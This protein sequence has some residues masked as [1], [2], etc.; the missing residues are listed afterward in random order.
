MTAIKNQILSP[1]ATTE[2]LVQSIFFGVSTTRKVTEVSGRGFGLNIVKNKI[3]SLGGS[4]KVESE[5]KNGTTFII[6]IPLTLAIIKALFIEA[7]G[8]TM[9]FL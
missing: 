5:P 1:Q 8:E 9:Q 4:V 7:G 6:E 2:E 3:E